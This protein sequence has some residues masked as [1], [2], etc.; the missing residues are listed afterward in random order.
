MPVF[1]SSG[2][3]CTLVGWYVSGHVCTLVQIC[4]LV[5]GQTKAFAAIV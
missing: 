1:G 2:S 4:V 3:V 5:G